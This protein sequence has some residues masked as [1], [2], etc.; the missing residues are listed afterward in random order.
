[1]FREHLVCVTRAPIMELNILVREADR[2][3]FQISY[4]MYQKTVSV[5]RK[6][7]VVSKACG[8]GSGEGARSRVAAL[9]GTGQVS[10]TER[11]CLHSR[12]RWVTKRARLV[13][14]GRVF[15]RQEQPGRAWCA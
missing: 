12:G 10:L 4:V 2:N 6:Q 14:G 13:P 7:S 9:P 8:T 1:M 11:C 5:T 3:F 15:G